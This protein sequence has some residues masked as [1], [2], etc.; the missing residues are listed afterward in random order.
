VSPENR[1]TVAIAWY[2]RDDYAKIKVL[3]DDGEVLPESYDAWLRQV[4]SIVRIEQSRGS[5]VLKAVILPDAFVAWCK[6]TSQRPNVDARTRHVNLAIEDYC[7]G[8]SP[9][10]L[11]S[12]EPA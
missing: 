3:M 7:A 5:S 11:L 9:A 2:H 6:A 8:Y 12:Y 4:E 1:R 10:V